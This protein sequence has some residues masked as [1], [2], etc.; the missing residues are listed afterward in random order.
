MI[1]SACFYGEF[2]C[3]ISM[4]AIDEP[5]GKCNFVK[6]VNVQ[7]KFLK[8]PIITETLKTE[9]HFTDISLLVLQHLQ[10][11]EYIQVFGIYANY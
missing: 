7:H 2:K 1:F 4:V 5:D 8:R 3:Y 10:G 11:K 9:I 6:N